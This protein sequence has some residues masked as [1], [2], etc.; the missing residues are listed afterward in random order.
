MPHCFWH[1]LINDELIHLPLVLH[2]CVSERGRSLVGIMTCCLFGPKPLPEPMLACCQSNSW[3]QNGGHLVQGGDKLTNIFISPPCISP[4][5]LSV[6]RVAFFTVV[7]VDTLSSAGASSSEDD[8]THWDQDKMA[9]IFQTTFS[10]AFLW[11]KM[12]ELQLRF[13]WSLF[14]R[15]HLTIFQH[16]F[17]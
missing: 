8:L 1:L 14:P 9:A 2:I 4:P 5:C 16:W 11:M 15:I 6:L 13:H 10:N 3:E 12:Y 17:T 7:S